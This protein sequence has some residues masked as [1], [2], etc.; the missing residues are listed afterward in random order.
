MK[1]WMTMISPAKIHVRFSDLDV[2][3]HV[4]NNVY[5]SYFE[6]ARVHYFEQMLGRNWNWQEDGIVLAKNE[7]EYIIPIL[8]HDEPM[9]SMRVEKIGTK[10]FTLSYEIKVKD[11]LYAKGASVLV[12]YNGKKQVSIE[13]PATMRAQLEQLKKEQ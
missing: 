12:C 1:N 3:G 6:I 7:V 5:S 11:K 10:S 9:V 2:L 8:L 4:N 13:I